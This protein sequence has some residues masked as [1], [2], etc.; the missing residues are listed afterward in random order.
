VI[1]AGCPNCGNSV[2]FRS[3]YS[4]HAVCGFCDTMVVRTASG[5]ENLGKVAEIQQDGSP[6]QVGVQGEYAGKAFQIV[7]RIQ[8]AYGDGYWN[9]WHLMYSNGQTGWIGE[10]MG[11]YFVSFESDI[12]VPQES[13]IGLGRG[14]KLGDQV[15]AVTGFTKNRVSAYEGELP[16][17]VDT[18]E[19]FST[20]DLRSTSG[21]AATIDYSGDQ[22][23][24]FEGE[25]KT[26]QS[27]NFTGLR[28]EGA[29]PDPAMGMRVPA[30]A[31][32]VDKFN[33][34]TCG[35]P[36][37]VNGGVRSK[38]LVCEYCGSAVDLSGSSLN[39]IWQEEQIRQKLKGK[40]QVPLGSVANLDGLEFTVIGYVRKS[41]TYQ[42]VEYPW[43][44]YLLYN[45]TNGYRWLVES[46]GH[47]TLMDTIFELPQ[48]SAGTPVGQPGS[49]SIVHDGETFRHFQTSTA[50][51]TA[52]AGEFYWRV[53]IGDQA[54]NFD[55]VAPPYTLSAESSHTGFVWAKGEYKTQN[56]IRQLFGIQ[57]ALQAPIGVAPA[58]PN[59]HVSD[60]KTVWGT[61]WVASLVGFFLLAFGVI[62]GS[63]GQLYQ[64]KNQVYQ[65]F[66]KNSPGVSEAF[67]I[68]GHGN[69]ALDFKS[70]PNNRWIFIKATLEN[71]E[72]K[73][74]YPIGVTLERFYGKGS[75]EERVR[76][77]GIPNGTYKLRWEVTSGTNTKT[78]DKIDPKQP[79][80][81]L[82]YTI[83]VRRGDAVWG[84]YFFMVLILLP[85]P[86]VLTAKKS[87]FET[88]R[89]YNSD[90]G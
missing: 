30:T 40:S 22:P 3:E 45:Y 11:E 47:Y 44:E 38:V 17:L 9:E 57:Q 43:I 33:C 25:Y 63:S 48:T 71:Q 15:Y 82:P 32:T 34:P 66:Q 85:I 28:Q 56:E 59:P 49:D 60:S 10:A 41:V 90:Y 18:K 68:K 2:P 29:P 39:V 70:Q 31:G 8:L 19:E 4:T 20:Y 1:Q 76:K 26:F 42:G 75:A 88:K 27:F 87:G 36:H 79:S 5:V 77:A 16:F 46:D 69:V 55:Y 14:L 78:P 64:T 51:V 12:G 54:A 73:K 53:K 72:T 50:V 84:W 7:G 62:T 35:A 80:T 83:T 37:S 67:E 61:F 6:L 86:I 24:L 65:T 81:K 58:Q 13:Q 23:S 89:W 52:V 21:K 74:T